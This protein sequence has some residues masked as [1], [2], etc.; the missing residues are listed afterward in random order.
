VEEET[1]VV[2]VLIPAHTFRMGSS[3]DNKDPNYDPESQDAERPAHPVILDAFLISKYELTYA[4]WARMAELSE[5]EITHPGF[6]FVADSSAFEVYPIETV[7]WDEC[8]RVLGGVG[9]SLPTEAQ[10]E[11][12]ARGN[13]IGSTSPSNQRPFT[14]KV[15]AGRPNSYGLYDVLGNVSEICL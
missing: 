6:R 3:T 1:G 12:A 11:C 15:G 2:L 5:P 8:L 7:T 10:W 14:E 13:G 4:Q 9:L